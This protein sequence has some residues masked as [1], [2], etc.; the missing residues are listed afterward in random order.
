VSIAAGIEVDAMMDH[1][2][3]LAGQFPHRHTGEP[4]ELGAARY[5]AD[6][7]RNVGLDVRVHELSV[8]GWEL[9]GAPALEV[10]D[11]EPGAFECVPF[12][13]SGS[14]PA[15]GLVGRLRYVGPTMV[16]GIAPEWQKYAVIDDGGQPRGF[17]VGR[18]AGPA[19]AQSGPP[20][21]FAG[22]EDGPHYSWPSCVI[23]RDDLA[24]LD[25]WRA[26]QREVRVRLRIAS[27]FKPG[28]T[29]FVVQGDLAGPGDELVVVGAHHDCMGAIG[30]PAS[31]DSPGGCDNASG[32]GAV[33]ELAR[34]FSETGYPRGL[35]FCTY[36]GEEWNLTG[37]R[38]YVRMLR[39]AREIDCVIAKVNVDQAAGGESLLV[40]ATPGS[41]EALA[42]AEV[43]RFGLA[44]RYDISWHVPPTPGSD[45]WPYHRA[46]VPVF[47][48]LWDPISHYHRA[49][50][51]P[52]A[53]TSPE[54]YIA[55]A[56]LIRSVV[57]R[58][59]TA[60]DLT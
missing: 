10:L 38:H 44:S 48:A 3:V 24:R 45:H 51:T 9:T 16:V 14:T 29:S 39:E 55:V 22:T 25:A 46:G 31:A 13:F 12:I 21:G 56:G 53:C 52:Q 54:Q 35:R 17:V 58:I 15:D 42:R 50:D 43:E 40:H 18:P 30:F 60:S 34:A 32:V 2:R 8:M 20:A 23:G 7:F 1:V 57:D 37:S 28:C 5:I 41:M 4:D 19:I 11:P 26:E 49:G 27:R 6:Q 59:G 47:Y 33:I 36:G